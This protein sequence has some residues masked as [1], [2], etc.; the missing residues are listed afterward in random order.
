MEHSFWDEQVERAAQ[1][2]WFMENDGGKTLNCENYQE[3]YRKYYRM[4]IPLEKVPKQSMDNF[5]VSLVGAQHQRTL[6][7]R[8]RPIFI[9][10][11]NEVKIKPEL[12]KKLLATSGINQDASI[13]SVRMRK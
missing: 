13:V 5:M 11:D 10:D 6:G 1:L 12:R 8:I 7:S 4:D 3:S 2:Y 9:T